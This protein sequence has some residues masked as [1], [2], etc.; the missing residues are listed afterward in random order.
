MRIL[1][2]HQYYL[3]PGEGGGS[4][5]NEMSHFWARE[6][7]RVTV[8]AGDLQY[9]TGEKPRKY[10]WRWLTKENDNGV[11]VWRC[12]VSRMYRRGAFGRAWAFLTFIL[13]SSAAGLLAGKADVV[14]ASSPPLF[15]VIPGKIA[16]SW[17]LIPWV[18]EMRDLLPEALVTLGVLNPSAFSTKLMYRIESWGCKHATKINVLTPAF[19]EDIIRRGLAPE[20]KI[21]LIPNGADD[22]SFQPGPKMNTVRE[23][24]G[25]GN[26]FVAIYTGAH[27]LAN[28]LDRLIETAEK[29]REHPD[30]LLVSVG[31]GPERDRL[32]Q[33]V[34]AR[35]I[36]NL[37]F[38]GPQ[39]KSAM[40]KMINAADV[41]IATLRA[42]PTHKT[43]YPNKVFDYMACAKPV[44]L[45]IDGVARQLVCSEAAAGVFVEPGDG[46]AMART[47]LDLSRHPQRCAEMGERGRAWV[48]GN[49][50][51]E[52]LA[53]R[54]SDIL[55]SLRV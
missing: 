49:L 19:R 42:T 14:I 44:V 17:R 24:F 25:W 15:V 50:R 53:R 21:T 4:R 13:S 27:G 11:I 3:M 52:V 20:A 16:A 51:R 36:Q 6:G 35:G 48:V 23:R 34:H 28:D 31:D 7:H 5:F 39:P 33:E 54:Y 43:V 37:I 47:I 22:E 8:I 12:H 10:R 9:T 45:A 18:F 29:L 26:K 38:Y 2:F 30:I 41:G 40:P 46:G 1:V 32:T 55:E